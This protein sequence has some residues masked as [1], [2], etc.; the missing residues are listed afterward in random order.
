MRNELGEEYSQF[1]HKF[2][3]GYIRLAL[4]SGTEKNTLLEL[5]LYD[6]RMEDVR[7]KPLL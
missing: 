7:N 3:K 2:L 6:H 4:S 1:H 5:L